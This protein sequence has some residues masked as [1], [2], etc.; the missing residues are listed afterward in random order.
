M[1]TGEAAP[2]LD[3]LYELLSKS[4]RRYVLYYLLDSDRASIGG[5]TRQVAAWERD[6]SIE[7]VSEEQQKSVVVSLLHNH[8]PRLEEHD[9][10]TV[11]RRRGDVVSGQCF[12]V[13][14]ST[15]KRA[16]EDDGIGSVVGPSSETFLYGDD[17]SESTNSDR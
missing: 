16:R 7:S 1:D 9:V 2:D 12:E 13:V 11:N 10:V 6:I 3:T 5:L 14:A 17:V 15:V 8:L 4:R